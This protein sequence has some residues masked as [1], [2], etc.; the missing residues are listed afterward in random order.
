ERRNRLRLRRF[1]SLM[2]M[3]A[4]MF[5]VYMLLSLFY[6]FTALGFGSL[7]LEQLLSQRVILALGVSV[8]SSTIVALIAVLFGIPTSWMLA[9]K[10]SRYKPVLETLI[11]TIP[12]AFPPGVVGTTYLLM[13]TPATSPI[14]AALDK[15]GIRLV[16]T[17][18]AMVIVKTFISA[19]FLVSLLA[20]KFQDIRQTGLEMIAKSLGASDFEAFRTVTLPLSYRTMVAG[21][22][23][24]WARA[25]G[26]IAGTIVFSGA[27]IPGVTQT[28]P[29]IIVFEAQTSL[30]VALSLALILAAFSITVLVS[31]RLLMERGEEALSR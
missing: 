26:E 31:F 16:N 25:I 4:A 11:V 23:R 24:C 19:P 30:P 10:D 15:L 28:M 20:G 27:I 1:D 13:F 21:A 9:Y 6:L 18:W 7:I 3:L 8:L 2:M 14:G 5:T 29:A 12:H 17:F 22:A